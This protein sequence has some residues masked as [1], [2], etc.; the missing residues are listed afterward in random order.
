MATSF[1]FYCTLAA[2]TW[3]DLLRECFVS[4]WRACKNFFVQFAK[5]LRCRSIEMLFSL[6]ADYRSRIFASRLPQVLRGS[7]GRRSARWKSVFI[8]KK[9]G[10]IVYRAACGCGLCSSIKLSFLLHFDRSA[11][12]SRLPN[13]MSGDN[14]ILRLARF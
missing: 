9:L 14:S 6:V 10:L 3:M 13:V 12:S 11:S 2:T 4:L 5:V 7:K 1:Y 8:L